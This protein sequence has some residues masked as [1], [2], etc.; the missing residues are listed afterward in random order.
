MLIQDDAVRR[1]LPKYELLSVLSSSSL[2]NSTIVAFETDPKAL[3]RNYRKVTSSNSRQ[4][5]RD[6]SQYTGSAP[7]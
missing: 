4:T 1:I 7:P 6:D 3:K 5:S 2:S